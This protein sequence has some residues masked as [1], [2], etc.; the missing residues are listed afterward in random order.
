MLCLA[1]LMI[2]AGLAG[3]TVD[4]CR[5]GDNTIARMS[6]TQATLPTEPRF[7]LRIERLGPLPLINHI[8]DRI[9]LADI[10]DRY[11]PSDA[12]CAVPHS[13]ALGVLLRSLIVE[14]EPIY[15]QQETVHGFADGMFGIDA[16]E[17]AHVC[18]D[19]LGRALDHLFDADRAALLTEVVLAV[20]QRFG[21]SFGELHNDSTSISFC[22]SYRA[23]SGRTIRGRSAPAIVYG[24]KSRPIGAT[25]SRPN[26]ASRR[27]V[28]WGFGRVCF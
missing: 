22:G 5:S 26:G 17:M 14:R 21:V 11:L 23:A 16:Q 1:C 18:D 2:V 6:G 13:R 19:R 4:F 20:G 3:M 10:L 9:G 15:R 28:F 8:I 25:E 7:D 27:H 12:R 24:V